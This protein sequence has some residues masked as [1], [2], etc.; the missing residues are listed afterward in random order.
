LPFRS[1]DG[2]MV[3]GFRPKKTSPQI[4]FGGWVRDS[5]AGGVFGDRKNI[6][7]TCCL[8]SG[9]GLGD[10]LCGRLL[11]L[12]KKKGKKRK[13][14]DVCLGLFVRAFFFPSFFL[15]IEIVVC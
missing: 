6:S 15:A 9:L 8:L 13:D 10:F 11:S 14:I 1:L 12:E 4:L 5:W 7:Q 2:G 3:E